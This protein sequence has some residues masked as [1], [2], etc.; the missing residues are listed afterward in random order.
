MVSNTEGHSGIT[1]TKIGSSTIDCFV[2]R[3]MCNLIRPEDAMVKLDV[4]TGYFRFAPW[5]LACWSNSGL[6]SLIY[7]GSSLISR[8][9]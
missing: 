7:V 9:N 2:Q 3:T 1:R 5:P 4:L 6:Q 8:A